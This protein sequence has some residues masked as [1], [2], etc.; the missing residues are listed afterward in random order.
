M[1]TDAAPSTPFYDNLVA[2]VEKTMAALELVGLE[3]E[4]RS[5]RA[6]VNDYAR[7]HRDD[8]EII[9]KALRLIMQMV[10]AQ[11]RIGAERL[12]E[13]YDALEETTRHL[14]EMFGPPDLEDV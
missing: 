14:Q 3:E 7:D 11:H 5:L 1:T 13:S 9:L 6:Y 10:L 8:I 2:D 12:A 4:L